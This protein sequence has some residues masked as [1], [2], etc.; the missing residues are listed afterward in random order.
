MMSQHITRFETWYASSG[1]KITRAPTPLESCEGRLLPTGLK[2]ID[3]FAGCCI[4]FSNS[5]L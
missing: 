2:T 3:N 5:C 4:L 1:G